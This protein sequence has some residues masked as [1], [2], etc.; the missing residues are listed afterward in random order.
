VVAATAAAAALPDASASCI[1]ASVA[2]TTP[3][4]RPPGGG[5]FRARPRRLLLCRLRGSW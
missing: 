4:I 2:R 3:S 5:R 1:G